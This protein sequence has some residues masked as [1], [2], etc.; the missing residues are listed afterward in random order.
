MPRSPGIWDRLFP[1]RQR[2]EDIII[3]HQ[4]VPQVA[5]DLTQD[6][7]EQAYRQVVS[8]NNQQRFNW[9]QASRSTMGLS[10]GE[11]GGVRIGRSHSVRT[12]SVW[13][14]DVGSFERSIFNAGF[15]DLP[16]SVIAERTT[17]DEESVLPPHNPTNRTKLVYQHVVENSRGGTDLIDLK[18]DLHRKYPTGIIEHREINDIGGYKLFEVTVHCIKL[19]E[20]KDMPVLPESLTRLI[21]TPPSDIVERNKDKRHLFV[22]VLEQLSGRVEDKDGLLNNNDVNYLNRDNFMMHPA[23]HRGYYDQKKGGVLFVVDSK[24][25]DNP[26]IR[27]DLS[28]LLCDGTFTSNSGNTIINNMNDHN[29]DKQLFEEAAR[30]DTIA[31]GKL[32]TMYFKHSKYEFYSKIDP[33]KIIRSI[34]HD[35]FTSFLSNSFNE[36]PCRTAMNP[37]DGSGLVQQHVDDII[38]IINSRFQSTSSAATFTR[39][40]INDSASTPKNMIKIPSN[41]QLLP[42]LYIQ[43]GT[44]GMSG[45]GV[46]EWLE[47]LERQGTTAFFVINGGVEGLAVPGQSRNMSTSFARSCIPLESLGINVLNFPVK[48]FIKITTQQK[49]SS[50]QR[51]RNNDGEI[52]SYSSKTIDYKVSFLLTDLEKKRQAVLKSAG[53]PLKLEDR[54]VF[55][56]FE[57]EVGMK[58]HLQSTEGV[59]KAIKDIANSGFGD[60]CIL[61]ADSSIGP[62]GF[63]LV[64]VPA[65]LGYHKELLDNHFFDTT[66]KF[67]NRL[68]ATERCGIHV[69]I[70]KRAFSPL[71]LGRFVSFINSPQNSKFITLMAGRA[72]NTYCSRMDVK[73]ANRHGVNQGASIAKNISLT[74]ANPHMPRNAVNCQQ[75]KTIEVRIFKSTTN[76]NNLIRKLEFCESLV[77]FCRQPMS[78]QQLTVYDYVEFL[79]QKE[80]RKDYPNMI[81]WLGS[82]GFVEHELKKIKGQT[83]LVHVYGVNKVPKPM[84]NIYHNPKRAR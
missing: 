34:P 82:K 70:D 3:E 38:S 68:Q 47:D 75:E 24:A 69:H 51:T 12:D 20:D 67:H 29:V 49:V 77:K 73:Q 6:A 4:F 44:G 2:T 33:T 66:N 72:P 19:L 21:T 50:N 31:L 13:L 28:V 53:K 59:S 43:Y 46:T 61:K 78:N 65:T 52:M 74:K 60:H 11:V 71:S 45:H 55:M 64:S 35:L 40:T 1:S 26:L 54:P 18:N 14:D 39:Y 56:G 17:I 84:D 42:G 62:H 15:T 22:E 36:S 58:K 79:L 41:S 83:R 9:Q 37:E 76:K 10:A 7:L 80:N 27:K 8:Y 57:L 81:L 5:G 23:I 30:G 16:L 25:T 63:E 32:N 48:L